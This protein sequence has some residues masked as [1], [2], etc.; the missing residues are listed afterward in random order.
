M[1]ILG[2][3]V[4]PAASLLPV[5][6][7]ELAKQLEEILQDEGVM[8]QP[9]WRKVYNNFRDNVHGVEIHPMLEFHMHKWWMEKSAT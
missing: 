4:H 5:A 1:R 2:T 7:A 8:I 9:Y 6:N 3:I